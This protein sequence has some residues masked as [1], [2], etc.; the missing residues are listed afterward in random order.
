MYLG[1][2][3]MRNL[4]GRK[5]QRHSSSA[6]GKVGGLFGCVF[7]EPL[8]GN[9]EIKSLEGLSWIVVGGES[10]SEARKMEADWVRSI[11]N[12]CE[13]EKVPFFFKQWG[14]YGEEGQE[15]KGK[16]TKAKAKIDGVA[17]NNWPEQTKADTVSA[18]GE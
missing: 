13:K 8:L 3:A 10:G 11:R 15:L 9:V 18:S 12:T 14:K 16:A 7:L 2:K 1:Y 6:G 4:L 17:H 5:T